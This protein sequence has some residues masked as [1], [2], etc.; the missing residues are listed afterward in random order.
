VSGT[1]N[2]RLNA[3]FLRVMLL[4]RVKELRVCFW[5]MRE[6]S[7]RTQV[8]CVMGGSYVACAL[9]GV[10]EAGDLGSENRTDYGSVKW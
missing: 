4:V 8:F 2:A 1:G 7:K 3:K 6:E 9:N 10:L 5:T